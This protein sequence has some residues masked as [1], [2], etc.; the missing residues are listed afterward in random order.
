MG[1]PDSN[2]ILMLPDDQA[3]DAR[4]IYR[5]QMFN[6]FDHKINLYENIEVDYR[7]L[8][9]NVQQFMQILTGRHDKATPKS[10]RLDSDQHSN[11]LIYMTGHGGDEFLKFQDSTEI[12]SQDISNAFEE[13][14]QKKR[15]KSILFVADT[16]Q[17]STLGNAVRSPNILT[18]GSSLLG[19]NSYSWGSDSDVGLS[20]TDRFTRMLPWKRILGRQNS[21][22]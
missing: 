1:I 8:D 22:I 10:K 4:N 6:N 7:G 13:M 18:I 19:E 14:Y 9:V 11:L 5:A 16:C 17:A 20:L 3:C 2:I 12:T 15:Y 21:S